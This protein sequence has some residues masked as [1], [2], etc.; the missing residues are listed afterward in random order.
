[1]LGEKYRFLRKGAVYK[2]D[3]QDARLN[4]RCAENFGIAGVLPD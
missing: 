4:T 2:S 1:M 3:E